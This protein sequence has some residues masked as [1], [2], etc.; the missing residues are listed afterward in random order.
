[1]LRRAKQYYWLSLVVKAMHSLHKRV[2]KV[3]EVNQILN[4]R[5]ER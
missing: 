5:D 2:D 4:E 1:M 3:R